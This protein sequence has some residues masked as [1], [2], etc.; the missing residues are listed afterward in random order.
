MTK[1]KKRKFVNVTPLSTNAK[2]RFQ[3][4][5][6]YFHG[7]EIEN[8]ENNNLYLQSLNKKYRFIV[9]RTGDSNWKVEK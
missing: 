4:D 3:E 8:E 1:S 7:C 9:N 5:M 6:N 2:N